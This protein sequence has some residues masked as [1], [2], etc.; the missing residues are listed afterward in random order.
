MHRN[1]RNVTTIC[2]SAR[3]PD[4][5]CQRCHELVRR[6]HVAVS[7][8]AHIVGEEFCIE[9]FVTLTAG[10]RPRQAAYRGTV[11][12]VWLFADVDPDDEIDDLVAFALE[13]SGE[14]GGHDTVLGRV[15]SLVIRSERER[16]Q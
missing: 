5:D 9:G 13:P 10:N 6:L 11:K 14:D 12:T 7:S 16:L 4:P 2:I 3:D 15:P 1:E 8:S